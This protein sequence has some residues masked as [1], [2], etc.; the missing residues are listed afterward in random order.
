MANSIREGTAAISWVSKGGSNPSSLPG[1]SNFL[2]G[3]VVNIALTKSNPLYQKYNIL[4]VIEFEPIENIYNATPE[5]TSPLKS[6]AFKYNSSVRTPLLNEIVPIYQAPGNLI[7]DIS[8]QFTKVYY[9]DNAV[10]IFI[11]SEVNAAPSQNVD[12]NKKPENK[13]QLYQ[14]SVSGISHN[15][16]VTNK[17][18]TVKLG[19][20]FEE[21]GIRTLAPLEGDYKLE[22]RFGNSIRF[23]GTPSKEITKDLNWRGNTIG[24]PFIMIRNG[25]QVVSGSDPNWTAVYEDINKDGSSVYFLQGQTIDLVLGNSNFNSYKQKADNTVPKQN[26]VVTT[27]PTQSA[28]VVPSKQD[29]Q[30]QLQEPASASISPS[31]PSSSVQPTVEDGDDFEF[32]PDTEEQVNYI[33]IFE[34]IDVSNNNQN[35]VPIKNSPSL[36]NSKLSTNIIS[37]NSST[38]PKSGKDFLTYGSAYEL[39]SNNSSYGNLGDLYYYPCALFNQGDPSWGHYNDGKYSMIK[40]G[41]CYNSFAMLVTYQKNNPGYTTAWFWANVIKS[42]NVYWYK[43]SSSVGL[44][45]NLIDATKISSIDNLIKNRPV[46]FEWDNQNKAI[47]TKYANRYTKTHHWMVINGKNKDGTYTIFDPNG[48]KIWK[49]Q[50]AEQ[51]EAG[52]IRLF[53]F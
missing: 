4:E 10:G 48:G 11:S 15:D 29:T 39:I 22:G 28:Q 37:S 3:R 1:K 49:N 43:M 20:Y 8:N 21:R 14:S 45:G 23:G 30:V 25:Q 38:P 6:I 51:I 46:M 18:T 35:N 52:L 47:N 32:L 16:N 27:P 26:I 53:Y 40:S 19:D 2:F 7:Q 34:Y 5:N 24:S 31:I 50:T 42:V 13:I 44:I 12:Q 36:K 9:Y 17:S 41:C 33:Q